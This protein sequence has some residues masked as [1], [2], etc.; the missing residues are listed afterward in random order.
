MPVEAGE[1]WLL[2][3][4]GR[5]L[6][7]VHAAC[8]V[9]GGASDDAGV[10]VVEFVYAAAILFIVA[11]GVMGGLAYA[12]TSAQSSASKA[13]ALDI[14]TQQLEEIRNRPYDA[15]GVVYADGTLG[16]P[17]GTV[18]ATQ[19]IGGRYTV[20]TAVSWARDA[21]GRA[22]Y[23]QVEITVS[24]T[25]PRNGSVSVASS[26][27]GKSDLIN[28]GDLSITVLDKKTSAPVPN[29]QV[30]I[31]PKTGTARSTYS[32]AVGVAFFGQIPMGEYTLTV[33]AVGKVYDPASANTVTVKADL[34][35]PMV[36]YVQD[37]STAR[38]TVTD[39]TGGSVAGA[40]VAL[41][42]SGSADRLATTGSD[43]IA[44]FEGL[45]VASYSVRV[46]GPFGTTSGNVL[47]KV[48]Q[49][50][51]VYDVAVKLAKVEST[52]LI[53][54]ARDTGGAPV[55]GATVRVTNATTGVQATGSPKTTTS[56]GV[57]AFS[58]VAAG[59]YDVTV[60]EPD[61]APVVQQVT[62]SGGLLSVSATL[63]P[64]ASGTLQ[65]QATNASSGDYAGMVT[66]QIS[67]PGGYSQTVV[68]D[69]SGA[70]TVSNLTA[71]TYTITAVNGSATNSTTAS[72]VVGEVAIV[73]I[74]VI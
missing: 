32:D 70:L 69:I 13:A 23:K 28:I 72:V 63:V 39:S 3:T 61:H 12:A 45:G 18:P 65:I 41:S 29:A 14:A 59:V 47:L 40:S 43:G 50:E 62:Y 10:T 58:A 38:V 56:D 16:D 11:M 15:I 27:Y 24:W 42:L 36:V 25:H 48:V 5:R 73:R 64:N 49:P 51:I 57:V 34:L 53:V 19:N 74:K 30:T 31:T 35:S 55:S 1:M 52:G 60:T 4:Q 46:T 20:D 44:L 71:G 9:G 8:G 37:P 68:S 67:G 54:L 66:F 7:R 26:V 17:P 22:L 33:T 6:F 2:N 21:S